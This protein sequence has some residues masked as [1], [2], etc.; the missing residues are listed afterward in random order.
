MK[1]EMYHFV[2]HWTFHAPID[3]VW[4]EIN[5]IEK[6]P[7][8]WHSYK[9]AMIRGEQKSS[10]VGTIV[11]NRVKGTL[12]YSLA[13]ATQI[14]RWEPP[15]LLELISTGDLI[16]NGKFVL[17]PRGD[18]TAVTFYWDVGTSNAVFNLLAKLPFVRRIMEKNHGVVM[19]DGY[20][21]LR[22]RVEK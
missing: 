8:W 9:Q 7:L 21:G 4:Q 20:R 17:E 11:D 5:D 10:G 15:M 22:A 18:G 14:T 13:Y 12:P 6:W 19:D 1:M 2:T 16:G 3:L